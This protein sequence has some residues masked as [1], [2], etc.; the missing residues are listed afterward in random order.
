MT[1]IEDAELLSANVLL[2]DRVDRRLPKAIGESKFDIL[3]VSPARRGGRSLQRFLQARWTSAGK[4]RR[5]EQFMAAH[6]L[7]F[8]SC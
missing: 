6:G 7:T 4:L 3:R 5:V 1:V 2:D 8:R